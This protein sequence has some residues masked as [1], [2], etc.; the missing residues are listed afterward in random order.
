MPALEV[1]NGQN[2]TTEL[3]VTST[4]EKTRLQKGRTR[5]ELA[6]RGRVFQ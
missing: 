1:R 2:E 6:L 3:Y 5:M 4:T